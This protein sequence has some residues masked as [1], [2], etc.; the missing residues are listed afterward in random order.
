MILLIDFRNESLGYAAVSAKGRGADQAVWHRTAP[1]TNNLSELASAMAK[2]GLSGR[3][4]ESIVVTLV[5]RSGSV[6]VSW[7]VI[8]TAVAAAN[9]LAFAWN[10]PVAPLSVSG[11]EPPERLEEMARKAASSAKLGGWVSAV[12]GGEPS[13]S[14]AKPLL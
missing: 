4:P 8:R 7:S 5:S 10:V 9:T 2:I 13:I 3:K 1:S 6:K 14:K 12:Y 11:D